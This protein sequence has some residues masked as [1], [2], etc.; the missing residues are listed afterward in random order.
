M[1]VICGNITGKYVVCIICGELRYVGPWRG[2]ML[3]EAMLRKCV[4]G[5]G[6]TCFVL[7]GERVGGAV[8]GVRV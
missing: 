8:V 2:N 5:G 4:S 7:C 3:Y 1:R 6:S